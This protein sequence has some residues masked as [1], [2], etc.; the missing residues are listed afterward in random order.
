M[1]RWLAIAVLVG[2]GHAAP[3]PGPTPGTTHAT[4]DAGTTADAGPVGLESNLPELAKRSVALYQ[5]LA[6]ALAE[7]NGDCAGATA[8]IDALATAYA[9]VT[10]ANAHV[11]HAG[12]A[13]VK[14][15]KAALAP[16]DAE[17][18]ASAKQIADSPTMR[19][20]SQDA[21]FAKA[22]DRLVGEP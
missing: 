14:E 17:L 21:G 7:S 12:H 13:R 20:C 2:C 11:L 9:E 1:M 15:L 8:K 5:D 10:A 16:Y 22:M 18:D 19:S 4:P 3:P 6:K